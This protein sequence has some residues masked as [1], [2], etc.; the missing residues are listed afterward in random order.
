MEHLSKILDKVTIQP[1]N[2]LPMQQEKPTRQLSEANYSPSDQ[3]E[4][5]VQLGACLAVQRTYGKQAADIKAVAK[6]F[7]EDL[8]KYPAGKVVQAIREWRL[9]S[10]E[11]PTPSDISKL[12]RQMP[13]DSAV[14]DKNRYT[15]LKVKLSSGGWLNPQELGFMKTYEAENAM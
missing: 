10:P 3:G 2:Q 7:M 4:I 5:V 13:T 12:I 8:K 1:S 14:V 6:I 15:S 11:F 9:E